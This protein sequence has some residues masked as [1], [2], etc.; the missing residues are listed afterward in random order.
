MHTCAFSQV[1]GIQYSGYSQPVATAKNKATRLIQS[2]EVSFGSCHTRMILNHCQASLQPAAEIV[3]NVLPQMQA[4]CAYV[5]TMYE[6]SLLISTIAQ[7]MPIVYVGDLDNS[8]YISMVAIDDSLNSRNPCVDPSI[9]AAEADDLHSGA[10]QSCVSYENL[11]TAIGDGATTSG[12]KEVTIFQDEYLND[13]YSFAVCYAEGDGSTSDS[14]WRD[15]YIRVT[16]SKI[17]S[18]VTT[19]VTHTDHGLIPDHV[20]ATPLQIEYT[21]TLGDGYYI[22]LVDETLGSGNPC[23]YPSVAGQAEDTVDGRF[24]GPLSATM[25][26]NI[27]PTTTSGLSTT[28]QFAVCYTTNALSDFTS[29]AWADSGIRVMKSK[30]TTIRYNN[31][32]TPAGQFL[33]DHE[34]ARVTVGSGDYSAVYDHTYMHKIPQLS[35]GDLALSYIGDLADSLYVA[36]VST[37]LNEG[38]PCA[39]ASAAGGA[40]DTTRTGVT[41][42]DGSKAFTFSSTTI[43][44]L[45]PAISYTI[46][47]AETATA[48]GTTDAAYTGMGQ[49]PDGWRD[50]YIRF[51]I[52][53]VEYVESHQVQ[54]RTQGHIANLGSYSLSYGGALGNEMFIALVDETANSYDACATAHSSASNTR[55]GAVQAGAGSQEVTLDTTALDTTANFAVCYSEGPD[56]TDSSTWNDSGIRVTISSLTKITYNND[57]PGTTATEQYKREMSSNNMLLGATNV[58]PEA[59]NR[60][61]QSTGVSLIYTGNLVENPAAIGASM[62][63]DQYLSI[64]SASLND[65]NPCAD[66]TV[67]A[68]TGDGEHSGPLGASGGTRTVTLNEELDDA[69]V[70]AVCYTQGDGSTSDDGWRDSY[71]RLY[72]TK[73]SSIVSYGISHVTEGMIAS[74]AA[75]NVKAV[76]TLGSAGTFLSLVDSTLNTYQPCSATHAGAVPDSSTQDVY[77]GISSSNTDDK[78]TLQTDLLSSAKVFA[79]CYAEG[80]GS[81]TDSTWADSGMRLMT[82]KLTSIKY[83]HPERTLTA[84]SCFG[85]IDLW[86]PAD[87]RYGAVGSTSDNGETAEVTTT[88]ARNSQLPRAAGV[89]VSYHGLT[90]GDALGNNM[91]VSLVDHTLGSQSNNPCRDASV[92]GATATSLGTADER[93]HSGVMQ[94]GASDTTVTIEQETGD[95]SP[96]NLLDYDTTFALCYAEVDGSTTDSTWRDSYIRITLSKIYTLTASDMVVYTEG[97]FANVPSLRVTYAGSLDTNMWL[98]L[99]EDDPALYPSSPCDKTNAG[100]AAYNRPWSEPQDST[101][102]TNARSPALQ[103]GTSSRMI[104]FDTSMLNGNGYKYV[105]CY[106]DGDGGN[107][108][109]TWMDSGLR[110]R[111]IKWTNAAKTRVVSGAATQLTFQLNE[112]A[113]S[114]TDDKFALLKNGVDCT[115]AP[116]AP[117]LSNGDEVMRLMTAV[118]ASSDYS[119]TLPSGTGVTDTTANG[120]HTCTGSGAPLTENGCFSTNTSTTLDG[121]PVIDEACTSLHAAVRCCS[122]DGTSCVSEVSGVCLSNVGYVAAQEACAGI[123][124]RLCTQDELIDGLCCGSGCGFDTQR[125][126]TSTACPAGAGACESTGIYND[127][128][129]NEGAYIMCFCDSDNGDGGCD[130]ANEFVKISSPDS[131]SSIIIVDAP[132][133]GRISGTSHVDYVRGIEM[134]SHTYTIIGSTQDGYEVQD[135]DK[136]FFQADDCSTVPAADSSSETAP[137]SLINYDGTDTSSTYQ[138]ARVVTPPTLTWNASGIEQ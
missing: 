120:W 56:A 54:H 28:V 36:L 111:F 124:M 21:G 99:I 80:D 25:S 22:S 132:R 98:S 109:S 16:I 9:A 130:D 110:I 108:D 78:H 87:C 73:V 31:G 46:C 117:Y 122:T 30:I 53:K 135:G 75:L 52:S 51:T 116:T 119:I 63:V 37:T 72:T 45:D 38:D 137:I 126:W 39:L 121:G 34:T 88:A 134:K 50:S 33:R 64:V 123:G 131:D 1:T 41:Q 136:I 20:S 60:L 15:S 8:Q 133:L 7:D 27:V 35:T 127:Y 10:V 92:A 83:M 2:I 118:D 26:T 125:I 100:A 14:T 106:A 42:A 103:A 59:T 77:S 57:Q 112:G 67:A 13:A 107:T 93:L 18:L 49:L 84:T 82:P 101:T 71:I 95:G 24:S 89:V 104:D 91:Y 114:T 96:Y 90:V 48:S 3:P 70:F 76:G 74:K 6:I 128:N 79:L 66:S 129:L 65:F 19:G 81:T 29:S 62:P 44:D 23:A 58:I 86:G 40:A 32:Q 5:Q 4:S 102:D 94:A 12:N 55:S 68:T 113:F 43:L 138:S 47:Y 115:N 85:D 17:Q 61:P 11:C 69:T 105:V 97:M